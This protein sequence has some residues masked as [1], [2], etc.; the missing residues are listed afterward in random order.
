MIKTLERMGRNDIPVH[1][2]RSSFRDW[3]EETTDFAG[4]VAEAA[5]GHVSA[6]KLKSS[7]V[8]AIDSRSA[9]SSRPPGRRSARHPPPARRCSQSDAAGANNLQPSH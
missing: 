5:L 6:T 3:T 7:I 9:A 2:F 1:G 8:A 4:A